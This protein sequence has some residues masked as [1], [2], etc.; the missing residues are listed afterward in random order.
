MVG[1]VGGGGGL[2]GGW[3]KSGNA[4]AGRSAWRSAALLLPPLLAFLDSSIHS[5]MTSLYFFLGCV[6]S[7]AAF[8]VAHRCRRHLHPDAKLM[9][10][11]RRLTMSLASDASE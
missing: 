1:G 8:L 11:H 6:S 7:S 3:R 10:I 5:T 9:V 2:K 4:K